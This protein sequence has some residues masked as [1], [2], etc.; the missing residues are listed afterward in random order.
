MV[1]KTCTDIAKMKGVT[2]QAL[3]TY[4]KTQ[5]IQPVGMR[6]KYKTY[7]AEAEPLASYKRSGR[8]RPAPKHKKVPLELPELKPAPKTAQEKIKR[9]SKPLNDLLAGQMPPGRK[10]AAFFYA[11]AL[12]LAKENSDAGLLFKLG[13][14]AAKE[15]ADEALQIQALKTEQAKEQIA[16]EKAERLKIENDLRRGL[17]M[18]RSTVKMIFGQMYAIDTNI[19]APLGQ[20]LADMLDA[21]PAEPERRIKIQEMIDAEIYAAL[22]NKK[23]VMIDFVI[24]NS[25]KI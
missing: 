18:D 12:K 15:D 7:D 5:G 4:I 3:N 20:K 1:L 13:Q 17:Y 2:K 10:P 16:Q 9:I 23:R 11:E 25:E 22:E 8:G 21:L 19:L 6:G 24:S 14:I